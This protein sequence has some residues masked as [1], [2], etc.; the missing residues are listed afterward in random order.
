MIEKLDVELLENGDAVVTLGGKYRCVLCDGAFL[1]LPY[2]GKGHPV[3]SVDAGK[4]SLNT[5]KSAAGLYNITKFPIAITGESLGPFGDGWYYHVK[6][7]KEGYRWEATQ[8]MGLGALALPTVR[9]DGHVTPGGEQETL[10]GSKLSLAQAHAAAWEA[11]DAHPSIDGKSLLLQVHRY[12]ESGKAVG[13]DATSLLTALYEFLTVGGTGCPKPEAKK[14]VWQLEPDEFEEAAK[15]CPPW[16]EWARNPDFSFE[17]KLT[18]VLPGEYSN[19]TRKVSRPLCTVIPNMEESS[20]RVCRWQLSHQQWVL[21]FAEGPIGLLI[22]KEWVAPNDGDVP[23]LVRVHREAAGWAREV[24]LHPEA[25]VPSSVEEC[26][27]VLQK[28]VEEFEDVLSCDSIE[29]IAEQLTR[30]K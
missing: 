28:L 4:I 7:N 15:D 12:I 23:P 17:I 14:T 18:R 6:P 3:L 24:P 26:A 30:G 10:T 9:P 13:S 20:I 21:G 27:R 22:T 8:E 1:A 5:E 29:E 25:F 2:L 11:I 16:W 19:F